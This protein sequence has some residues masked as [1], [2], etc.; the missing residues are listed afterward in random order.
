MTDS[1]ERWIRLSESEAIWSI[2]DKEEESPTRVRD[3]ENA[4]LRRPSVLYAANEAL[5]SWASGC[6]YESRAT[7]YR[8]RARRLRPLV[9]ERLERAVDES[10]DALAEAIIVAF[11]LCM[12]DLAYTLRDE[13]E[14]RVRARQRDGAA[15]T[16]VYADRVQG[17]RLR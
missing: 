13:Q 10:D 12:T 14:R 2:R 1:Q 4:T 8:R 16:M 17:L 7:K 6:C 11:R 5:A 15:W 9:I 3:L